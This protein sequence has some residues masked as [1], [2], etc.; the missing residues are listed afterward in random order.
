MRKFI[1]LLMIIE[2]YHVQAQQWLGSGTS[3]NLIY[4]ADKIKV[5]YGPLY[6]DWTYQNNWNGNAQQWAGHIGFNAFRYNND[7]KDKFYGDNPYTSKGV[8]EGSSAGFRWLFR[9]VSNNDSDQQH[10]LP[11]LM[12]LTSAGNL[13]IGTVSPDF[14]LTVNGKIKAEEIQVVVDVADYVFEEGYDLKTLEEV[15]AF[16]LVNK[17]LPNVPGRQEV[18]ANGYQ[19]GQMTNKL[20]EKIEEMTLYMI[21]LKE[22][23][24]K[25]N[26]RLANMEKFI[27]NLNVSKKNQ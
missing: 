2:C 5:G 15:K 20:L 19:V 26:Q 11:E 8:F 22:E 10:L 12:R 24:E 13:G 16:I 23:N 21:A 3:S 1:L 14:K 6:L 9:N 7:D 18:E 4:R 25:L 17:H 27:S